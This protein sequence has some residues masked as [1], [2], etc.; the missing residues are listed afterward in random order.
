M[1]TSLNI[2]ESLFKA[3]AEEAEK[4]DKTLSEMISYWARVGWKTLR[5]QEAR[6]PTKIKP[7]HLGGPAIVDL[8]CR[9]DWM[10]NLDS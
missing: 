7:V 3:A 2:E 5:A 9:R 8:N 4:R 6:R 1:K 10:D